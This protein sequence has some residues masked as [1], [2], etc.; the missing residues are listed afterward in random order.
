MNEPN[1]SGLPDAAVDPR[2]QAYHV[3]DDVDRAPIIPT[4]PVVAAR[5]LPS[6]HEVRAAVRWMA[7]WKEPHDGTSIVTRRMLRALN[8]AGRPVFLPP[9]GL[10]MR[11]AIDPLVL[12][13]VEEMY[14]RIPLSQPI[15]FHHL[16]PSEIG[17]R[18]ALYPSNTADKDPEGAERMH[19]RKILFSVWEQMPSSGWST[20]VTALML[21]K[22]AHHVVPCAHNAEVLR[23]AGVPSEKITVIHHPFEEREAEALSAPRD[24]NDDARTPYR[25]YTQGK[26]EPRKD[27]ITVIRAFLRAFGNDA[28]VPA[29]LRVLTSPWWT[30]KKYPQPDA[31]IRFAAIAE[32]VAVPR[33]EELVTID[34]NKYE[35]MVDIHRAHDCYVSASHG[36]AWG[37]PAH[38]ACIA[39]NLL[40][41]PHYGGFAEFAKGHPAVPFTVGPVDFDY[42]FKFSPAK[43]TW[44]HV[45]VDD[46]AMSML[47]AA[48]NRPTP[49][50]YFDG[51]NFARQ[52]PVEVGLQLRRVVDN[53]IGPG[54]A[55]R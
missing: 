4:E 39:G 5:S 26:W 18:A 20:S 41:V 22:F 19:G 34:T 38:D 29:T 25:F 7:S 43:P 3:P 9:A 13:E 8:A 28:S 24:P 55:W 45:S 11:Y 15:H 35:S 46:L 42:A 14:E 51:D 40:L 6:P 1:E 47:S 48:S 10:Q 37:M 27:P 31:A 12:H 53:V 50:S 33:A 30:G 21:A 36:E 2:Y 17:I 44:A 23:R 52:N 49:P 32:G 16:V 54:Y